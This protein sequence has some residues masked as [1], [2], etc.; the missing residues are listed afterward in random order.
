MCKCAHNFGENTENCMW[1]LKETNKSLLGQPYVS[2]KML[3]ELSCAS[4]VKMQCRKCRAIFQ[5]KHQEM[6]LEFR[7][8][9]PNGMQVTCVE[10]ESIL[11][12]KFLG[13]GFGL[14]CGLTIYELHINL[15]ISVWCIIIIIVNTRHV[16]TH[17]Q[18]PVHVLLGLLFLKVDRW[19]FVDKTQNLTIAKLNY[20]RTPVFRL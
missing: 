9:S 4:T 12:Q 10:R 14:S 6:P 16:K 18:K 15:T 7:I 2:A 1:V 3:N 20:K 11:V 17:S 5:N 8:R 13:F 19:T